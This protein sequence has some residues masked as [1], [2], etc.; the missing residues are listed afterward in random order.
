MISCHFFIFQLF[1][2][3]KGKERISEEKLP[4]S[5]LILSWIR[6]PNTLSLSSSSLPSTETYKMG[7]K[8]L[9]DLFLPLV[10]IPKPEKLELLKT[11]QSPH[12]ELRP[13]WPVS[14]MVWHDI[15]WTAWFRMVWHSMDF[16]LLKLPYGWENV[17][18][19]HLFFIF[20]CWLPCF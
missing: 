15:P 8:C 12:P 5:I 10:S 3:W 20:N 1:C 7:E 6:L 11:W 9:S 17:F 19:F 14:W 18:F 16:K 13:C 2:E 4:L